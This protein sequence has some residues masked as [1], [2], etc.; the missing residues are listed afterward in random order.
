MAKTV[1]A[2]SVLL[3]LKPILFIASRVWP[4]DCAD[5]APSEPARAHSAVRKFVDNFKI[6]WVGSFNLSGRKPCLLFIVDTP[7]VAERKPNTESDQRE[8][9]S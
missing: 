7:A 5:C 9:D 8:S 4:V 3:R 2:C 1:V 6:L